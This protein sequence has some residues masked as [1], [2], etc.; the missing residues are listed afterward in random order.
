MLRVSVDAGSPPVL[1]RYEVI[2]Q[3][4]RFTPLFPFD[5]GRSYQVRF[6]RSRVDGEGADRAAPLTATVG[7]PA[8]AAVPTTVVAHVY[9]SGDVLPENQ[10]RMYIEFSAPMGRRSGIEHVALLDEHGKEVEGPFLPLDYEFWNADRTRFTVFFDPGRV[11]DG[12][13][14]NKQM[15]PVLEAGRTYTLLVRAGLAGHQRV[16]VERDLP[17]FVP[18]RTGRH[19]AT[20]YHAMASRGSPRRW[21]RAAAS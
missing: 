9:P 7:L 18:R 5:R 11:K 12:I 19:P 20:R 14:P 21:T 1:G 13:L 4:L 15:G 10:L 6:D 2:D 17:P 3:A 16:A 8:S